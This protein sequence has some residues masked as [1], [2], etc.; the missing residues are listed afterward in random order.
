[1]SATKTAKSEQTR[2]LI[3]NT[4]MRLF[5]ERGYEQTTMRG[6]AQEAGVS[7]G[8]AYY[9]F[10]GKEQLV[11][12]FYDRLAAE[13]AEAA[14]AA[15]QG[16]TELAER[17]RLVLTTWLDVAEPYHAFAKHFF[18]NAA[19]PSS[20]LSPFSAESADAR[21]A[22]ID[23]H[24]TVL[25]G[26]NL[27]YDAEIARIMPELLWLHHLALVLYWAHDRTPRAE[28][29]RRLAVRTSGTVAKAVRLCKYK[30]VRPLVREADSMLREFLITEPEPAD[31]EAATGAKA[32][33][34][35]AD[36]D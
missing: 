22:V 8:S 28:R 16:V 29:T 24:R 7:V 21:E 5:E 34:R 9:Y 33:E 27:R 11:Q 19:D 30:V 17:I 18:R 31:A 36:P 1:M 35:K 14:L 2:S 32:V 26:S 3:L 12:G 23:L 25:S 15:M 4:A 10:S 20:P 6:I 13:H